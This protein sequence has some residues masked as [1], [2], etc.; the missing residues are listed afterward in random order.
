M[1]IDASDLNALSRDLGELGAR[2]TA[3]MFD[4]YREAGDD[5]RKTWQANA[6][7]TSGT[8]GRHYPDSITAD[9]LV[10]RQ[11]GVEVGPDSRLPQGSMGPGFEF[12]SV[13]QPPHLDGQRAADTVGPLLERRVDTALTILLRQA[14]L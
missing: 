9:M 7:E 13:N 10:G 4:V 14:D 8:H 11:I 12:G 2:T 6:R 1:K 3:A 5:L